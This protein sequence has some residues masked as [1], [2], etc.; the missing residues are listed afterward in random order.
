MI[1]GAASQALPY[2]TTDNY[3]P[4]Y[5]VYD[6]LSL[7][8]VAVSIQD[9]LGRNGTKPMSPLQGQYSVFLQA[10]AGGPLADQPA[11]AFISQIGDVPTDAHSVMFT[12]DLTVDLNRLVVSL[13]GTAIPMQLFSTGDTVNPG[14]GPMETFI[15]DISA[16]AG[17]D[18]VEFRFTQTFD[19]ANPYG[20]S[21][22]DL[23]AIQ[24]SPTIAPEPSTLALL[25][26]AALVALAP[27]AR[28]RVVRPTSGEPKLYHGRGRPW[29][30]PR[31]GKI[32]TPDTIT[33][34]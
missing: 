3:W 29:K 1:A 13:N 25:T 28:R 2:W 34:A 30:P 10:G 7:G 19:P 18:N 24:F 6:T 8:S 21:A 4:G 14:W 27:L 15:G 22:I 12:T 5:V 31:P 11:S 23:D 26:I 32:K 16:F 20:G 17:Q 33:A 9:G